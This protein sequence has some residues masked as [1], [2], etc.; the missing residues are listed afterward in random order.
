MA[1]RK[2]YLE[3]AKEFYNE[4]FSAARCGFVAGSLTRGAGTDTSDI[5]LYVVYD[6]RDLPCAYRETVIYRNYIIECFVQNENSLD[7]FLGE[8]PSRGECVAADMIMNGIVLPCDSDYSVRLKNRARALYDKSPVPLSKEEIESRRYG[9][10]DL[11]DDL[12]ARNR[13]ELQGTLAVLHQQLGDF[14]LRAKGMWSGSRKSLYRIMEQS[15]P[16]MAAKFVKAFD[17][18]YRDENFNLLTDLAD[19][20][21]A[22]YGGRLTDGYKSVAPDRVNKK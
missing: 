14:Y 8:E 12:P 11:L 3:V 7:Y 17:L 22:P 21:L 15:A 9:L 4:R 20:I 16:E 18:A 5:D 1:Q 6:I 10:T 13:G 2:N 19:E